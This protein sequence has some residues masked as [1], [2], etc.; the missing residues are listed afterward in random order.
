MPQ[1]LPSHILIF[2]Q[3]QL[4]TFYREYFEKQ[5]CQ[6]SSPKVDIRDLKAVQEAIT[7]AKPDL[8]INAVAKTNIDWCEQNRL[9]CFDINTLAADNIARSAEEQG[10]YLL[11][12]SSGCVQESKT[13]QEIHCE[14][15]PVHP[16]CFYSWTKVWAEELLIDR[17]KH[18]NLKT[19]ILR[20]RQLLSAMVSPRNAITKMLTYNKFI[21]TPNSCTIVEDLMWATD[22]LLKKQATAI[23]NIAN[24]GIITPYEIA[25]I[26][27][28]VIKPDLA[29]TKISKAD[30]NQMTLARRVDCVLDCSRL[31]SY[32]IQL[33]E[34]HQRLYEIAQEFKKNLETQQ[35]RKTLEQTKNETA[36]KLSLKK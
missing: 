22:E 15:D 4:G 18:G 7:A 19:L 14:T 32:G 10:I 26:I 12:L 23:I 8:I 21:D 35:G 13:A 25:Q 27:K 16:I 30:L 3:G 9:E 33:P 29:V 31:Q 11:H 2:G 6:I 28:E 24:P 36:A 17:A 1:P 34:I 5:G 20:P